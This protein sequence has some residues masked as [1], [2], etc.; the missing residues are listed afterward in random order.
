MS[1]QAQRILRQ[2]QITEM[3]PKGLPAAGVWTNEK[4]IELDGS[5]DYVT[6]D[7]V[8]ADI[9]GNTYSVSAWIR[10]T[11]TATT[12]FLSFNDSGYG[13]RI[14]VGLQSGNVYLYDG[15]SIISSTTFVS[16]G[17]WRNICL[18]VDHGAGETKIYV[19]GVEEISHGVSLDMRSSDLFT[20]GA[21]WDPGPTAGDYFDGRMDEVSAWNKTL[22]ALDIQE[23]WNSGD[24]AD[25]DQHTSAANL[26]G[27]WT[28]GDDAGDDATGLFGTI[29]D[30]TANANHA[31]PQGTAASAIKTD[32]PNETAFQNSQSILL[33]GAGEILAATDHADFNFVYNDSFSLSAWVK[34]SDANW[35]GI[36]SKTDAGPGYRGWQLGHYLSGLYFSIQS[37]WNSVG[38]GVY[39]G[40]LHNGAWRCVVVSYDGSADVSGVSMWIDNV[41]Q[42]LSTYPGNNLGTGDVTTTENLD[43]GS[44]FGLPNLYS[45]NGS[46]D[47]VAV[48]NKEISSAE[49]A[50]IYNSG[51]PGDL[52]A[53]SAAADLISWWRMGDGDDG[54]GENDSSDS[55]D[56]TARVYDMKGTHDAT[57]IA[58]EAVDI[59]V[60]A[61]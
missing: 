6:A 34:T 39:G 24:A 26:Q 32:S 27:W 35:Q 15:S 43:L 54:A 57:P 55:T 21:E 33:D 49:A 58:T 38:L 23:I 8:C 1:I 41:A 14:L 59:V 61:P 31:T 9:A 45:W 29:I 12:W 25:L 42:S 36:I 28:M 22:S 4:C 5:N 44:L 17:H 52:N 3:G 37:T 10:T 7:G 30:Q 51:S 16:D 40:T 60:G 20:M 18:T 50:D 11:T 53:H 13:N 2:R 48:W 47:E 56:P 46:L 19:N